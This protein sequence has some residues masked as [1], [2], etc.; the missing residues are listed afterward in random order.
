[1]SVGE[2]IKKL[3]LFIAVIALFTGGITAPAFADDDDDGD[4]KKSKTLEQHCAKKKGFDKLVCEAI[5]SIQI[6][7]GMVKDDVAQ[8]Q[9]DVEDLQRQPGSPGDDFTTYSRYSSVDIFPQ[10]FETTSVS[11]DDGD[12]ATGGGVHSDIQDIHTVASA[13]T[14]SNHPTGWVGS[15]ENA[16]FGDGTMTVYVVCIEK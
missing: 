1:V 6:M 2:D 15:A 11:C 7:L 13:P 5:L 12:Q 16:G 4:K 8:L 10:G 9:K 14:G 3:F